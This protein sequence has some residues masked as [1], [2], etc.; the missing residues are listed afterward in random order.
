M[1][2]G[3]AVGRLALITLLL[4]LTRAL[5]QPIIVSTAPADGATGVSTTAAVVFTFSEAMDPIATTAQF[6]GETSFN[7]LTTSNVWSA[8]NTVLT[9]TPAPAFPTSTPIFWLVS[10]QSPDGTQ[11]GGTPEGSFTTGTSGAGGGGGGGTGTNQSTTFSVGQIVYYDEVSTGAPTL[12]TNIPYLFLGT[13]ILSSNRSANS[14]TLEMPNSSVSNLFQN[15]ID[16]AQFFL[17]VAD[18]NETAFDTDFGAGDYIFTVSAATSNQQ[19]IVNYP[20]TLAQPSAPA[21]V[22]YAAAQSVNPAQ[23]FTLE[24]NVGAG[25][26]PGE[27]VFVS[28][29]SV[30]STP[31][32]GASNALPGTATSVQI[33]ANTLQPNT[34]YTGTIGFYNFIAVTNTSGD[35]I[36]QAFRESLT[37]FNLITIGAGGVTGPITLTNASWS[38]GAFGFNVTSAPGQ[39]LIIQY[40]TDLNS[41]QWQ[42]LLVTNSATGFIQVSYSVNTANS[43][44][45]YRAQAGP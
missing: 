5:A 8:G 18:T 11:L 43:H 10:G 45:F 12:D 29:G 2:A 39:N 34:N 31:T 15:P 30:F 7:S 26:T 38:G 35:Y 16:P 21:L 44:V 27:F 20:A 6:L 23:P 37:Q 17:S 40:S 4:G 1:A 32:L 9:C 33:P 28:V 3:Y 36:T 42:T 13:F 25:G 14:A 22:N 19:V 41:S 24:W